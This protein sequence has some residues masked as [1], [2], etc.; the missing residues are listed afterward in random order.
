MG[1]S[2]MGLSGT[3]AAKAGHPS[4]HPLLQPHDDNACTGHPLTHRGEGPMRGQPYNAL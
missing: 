1:G 3:G 2:R 4:S